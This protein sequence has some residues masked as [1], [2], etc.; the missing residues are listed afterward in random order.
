MMLHAVCALALEMPKTYS[1]S[2]LSY[3]APEAGMAF[4]EL[5]NSK[6]AFHFA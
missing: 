6:G 5:T 3:I 1:S 2:Q 4:G